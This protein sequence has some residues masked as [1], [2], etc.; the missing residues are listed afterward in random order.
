[1]ALKPLPIGIQTFRDI[2][3]GSYLYVDKTRQIKGMIQAA[4]CIRWRTRT[5]KWNMP[6]YNIFWA[7]NDAWNGWKTSSVLYPRAEQG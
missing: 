3:E 7:H 4:G 2:V 5:T 1:M 6:F